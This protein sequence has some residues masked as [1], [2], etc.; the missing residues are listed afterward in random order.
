M[1]EIKEL[2]KSLNQYPNHYF[3]YVSDSGGLSVAKA[4]GNGEFE[5]QGHI[6]MPLEGE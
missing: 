2:I 4:D 5:F 6:E 1:I 3:V